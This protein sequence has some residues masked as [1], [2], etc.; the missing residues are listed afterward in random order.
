MTYMV[1]QTDPN[2]Q[3]PKSAYLC[4]RCVAIYH[5]TTTYVLASADSQAD[6]FFQGGKSLM[7]FADDQFSLREIPAFNSSSY[8]SL[9]SG[10]K[11]GFYFPFHIWDH[12]S[13]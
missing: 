6:H 12:P 5:V 1:C 4:P 2:V 9:V 7:C 10:F 8:M 13:R 3:R 11:H